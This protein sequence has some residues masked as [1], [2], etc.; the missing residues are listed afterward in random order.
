MMIVSHDVGVMTQWVNKVACLQRKLHFH[1]SAHDFA[2]NHD[3]ILQQMY[4]DS[5]KMLAHHH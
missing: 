2:H 4:G 3:K 5:I 1:G